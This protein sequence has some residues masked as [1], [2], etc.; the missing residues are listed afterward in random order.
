[1]QQILSVKMNK[2]TLFINT[3]FINHHHCVLCAG[4]GAWWP[5]GPM[6]WTPSLV[7]SH[8]QPN[9][10]ETSASN[11]SARPKSTLPPSS[12][13][14]TRWAANWPT[15]EQFVC[16][17][18]ANLPLFFWLVQTDSHLR[19]YLHIIEDK[20]VYPVIYDSNGVVLSMP[21]IINGEDRLCLCVCLHFWFCSGW[22]K[23]SFKTLRW[24]LFLFFQGTIQK[25]PWRQRMSSLSARPQTWPRYNRETR[26][27]YLYVVQ[28]KQAQIW[29]YSLQAKI[30][31]D[32]MVTMF[33]E[34]CSQPFT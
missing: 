20:P 15:E 14:S 3:L 18:C 13:V 4:R 27:L 34:Y 1:M 29:L 23:T 11:P 10:L 22:R 33:S 16:L 12:W 24:H 32:M 30:V 9:L 26:D 2:N 25:S 5:S 19:H 17:S 8:T 6:T 7:L 31:L 28:R 21:P